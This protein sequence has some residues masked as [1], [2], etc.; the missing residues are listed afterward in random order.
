LLF[1]FVGKTIRLLE[2]P[3]R[4]LQVPQEF[5]F[6]DYTKNLTRSDR[7]AELILTEGAKTPVSG[8]RVAEI[9]QAIKRLKEAE[10]SAPNASV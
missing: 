3:D 4:H 8:Y 1:S 2:T 9:R 5:R 7:E 10:C 6:S